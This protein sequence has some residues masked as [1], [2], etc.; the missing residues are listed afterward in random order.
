[1]SIR[2]RTLASGSEANVLLAEFDGFRLLIDYNPAVC[3]FNSQN[4]YY[5]LSEAETEAV[6]TILRITD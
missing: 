2:I 3:S 5:V 6:N 4:S 1:M